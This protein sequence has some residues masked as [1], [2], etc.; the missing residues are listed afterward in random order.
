M[1]WAAIELLGCVSEQLGTERNYKARL[2]RVLFP[3]GSF[4]ISW[5]IWILEKI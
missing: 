4:R 3:P 2:E 1:A 5:C